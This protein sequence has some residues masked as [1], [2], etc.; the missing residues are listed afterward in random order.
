MAGKAKSTLDDFATT[1]PAMPSSGVIA[2]FPM[3]FPD[4]SDLQNLH[5]RDAPMALMRM[6][7]VGRIA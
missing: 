5:V 1:T 4:L 7:S 2:S 3:E 6:G